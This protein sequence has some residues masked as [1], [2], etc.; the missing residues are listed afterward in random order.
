MKFNL[1]AVA[2]LMSMTGVDA[3][4]GDEPCP[5]TFTFFSDPDCTQQKVVDWANDSYVGSWMDASHETDKGC[6]NN[7]YFSRTSG[8]SEIA[9]NQLMYEDKECKRLWM[10][11]GSI[12][13]H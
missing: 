9:L 12:T 1:A 13:I 10:S 8:C 5:L 7:G 2:A 4:T 11:D 6:I 3:L